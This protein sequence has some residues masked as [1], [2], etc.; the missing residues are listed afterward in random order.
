MAEFYV[1]IREAIDDTLARRRA[2][3]TTV[4]RRET[5]RRRI[6]RKISFDPER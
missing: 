1:M 3:P 5:T 6:A 4:M 2:P